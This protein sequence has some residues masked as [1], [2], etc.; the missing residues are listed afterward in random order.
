MRAIST[1][2]G[3]D[4]GG[5]LGA[6]RALGSVT[7]AAEMRLLPVEGGAVAPPGTNKLA[8]DE[9]PASAFAAAG[10][11]FSSRMPRALGLSGFF[12]GSVERFPRRVMSGDDD[13][14]RRQRR[15]PASKNKAPPHPTAPALPPR[16][17]RSLL[18]RQPRHSESALRSSASAAQHSPLSQS[19]SAKLRAGNVT[20]GSA[21]WDVTVGTLS[22]SNPHRS[23]GHQRLL[24]LILAQVEVDV[25]GDGLDHL[26]GRVAP[27]ARHV[28][29]GVM[30]GACKEAQVDE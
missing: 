8:A 29:V 16:H 27:Q 30:R 21:P 14:D 28:D 12:D 19:V 26:L 3:V 23:R 9:V 22:L 4:G 17:H 15:R 2:G 13:D 6:A 5:G 1:P 11:F 18:R 20:D 25:L 24:F 7:S 10:R